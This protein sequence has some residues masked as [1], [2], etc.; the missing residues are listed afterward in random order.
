MWSDDGR[1]LFRYNDD[2]PAVAAGGNVMKQPCPLVRPRALQPGDRVAI[3]APSSRYDADALDRGAAVLESWGLLVDL[4][5]S[6]GLVRYLAAPDDERAAQLRAAFERDDIAAVMAVRGGYG[7]ARLYGRF[8]AAAARAH[9]KIFL[10]YSDVTLLLARLYS[11]AGLVCF[12]G[13]MAT[14]D[15]ARLP[16]GKLE[17]FRSFLFG[18]EGWWAGENLSCVVAGRATGRLAGGCLSVLVTTLGTPYEIDTRGAVLFLEDIVEPAYRI[19]RMLTHLAHAGKLD[20]V[21]AI[22]LGEFHGCEPAAQIR[23]IFEEIC[24]ARAIP[25][26]A[27]FDAGHYSGGAVVPIG[28]EV[29]VDADAG[30]VELLEPVFATSAGP[31]SVI[32]SR[33]LR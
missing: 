22:V 31:A 3:V 23:E 32:V 28:C 18:E 2:S 5:Q 24:G 19:D 8:D 14:S 33:A 16:A 9:P 27:G 12:H 20:D 13:P 10:G 11:E 21:A 29:R 15:L 26:V 7:A 4:P 6:S 1:R 30:M 25:V 17:R